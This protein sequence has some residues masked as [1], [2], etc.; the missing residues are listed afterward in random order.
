MRVGGRQHAVAIG[1]ERRGDELWLL[2][3]GHRRVLSL[4]SALRRCTVIGAAVRDGTLRVRFEPD[5]D[6][7][8]PL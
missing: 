5:P 6:L 7:W 4:P 2:V 3:G 8:R 1:V